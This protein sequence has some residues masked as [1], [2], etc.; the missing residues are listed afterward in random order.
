MGSKKASGNDFGNGATIAP[1]QHA[2]EAPNHS[3]PSLQIRKSAEIARGSIQRSNAKLTPSRIAAQCTAVPASATI[4]ATLSPEPEHVSGALDEPIAQYLEWLLPPGRPRRVAKMYDPG[5]AYKYRDISRST[6]FTHTMLRAHAA[7]RETWACRLDQDGMSRLGV[8]EVDEGGRAA[9]LAVLAAATRHHLTAMAIAVDNPLSGHAGGHVWFVYAEAAAAAAIAAQLRHIATAAGLPDTTE[10]WPNNQV[11]RLPFGYHRWART[12]GEL[13][14]QDGEVVDLDSDLALGF[15]RVA[16]LPQNGA[17]LA[18]VTPVVTAFAT[19]VTDVTQRDRRVSPG[20]LSAERASLG[21]VRARFNREHQ[22]AQLLADWGAVAT[23]GG[24]SCPCGAPHSHTTTLY[25]SKL[26]KLFS[27]SPQCTLYTTKGY[28]AFG[29]YVKT[30]HNDDIAAALRQLNPIARAQSAPAH[31]VADYVLSPQERQRRAAEAHRKRQARKQQ[32]AETLADVRARAAADTTLIPCDRAVLDILMQI[33]GDRGWCRPSKE[34]IAELSGYSLGSVKRSLMV[35][36]GRGYFVSEGDGGGPNSTAIRTFLRGSFSATP[37]GEMIHESYRTCDL[38]PDSEACEPGA[39]PPQPDRALLACVRELAK[40]AAEP[41]WETRD[42][43]ELDDACLEAEAD[44]LVALAAAQLAE[45][46]SGEVPQMPN[47]Q[48]ENLGASYIPSADWTAG[49][50]L[51]PFVDPTTI[52][53]PK[54]LEFA[55]PDAPAP[56]KAAPTRQRRPRE[57]SAIDRY[58]V[59]LAGMEETQLAGELKKHQRTLKK[60]AGAHWLGQVRAKV[61]LV[62]AEIDVRELATRAGAELPHLSTGRRPQAVTLR[63]FAL[64]PVESS[65]PLTSSGGP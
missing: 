60:H 56:E 34:R 3:I 6:P 50:E 29:F 41:G 62:Q 30:Q 59:D 32:A 57:I 33:A 31:S 38:I 14:T 11:I 28:D 2:E 46:V 13:L 64:S 10:I 5:H 1:E 8:I 42:Y 18:V 63:G 26:G 24:F 55:E 20:E 52:Q 16:S 12:R 35:L 43:A 19:S 40:G 44:R 53:I 45:G 27:Y 17:P 39:N 9:V 58:R 21:E 7:G 23:P 51:Q 49:G 54:F 25:I 48:L 22:L 4:A 61:E 65:P 37:A 15:E 47:S 36:E